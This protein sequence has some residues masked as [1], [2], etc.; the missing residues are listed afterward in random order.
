MFNSFS[1][2]IDDEKSEHSEH[3]TDDESGLDQDCNSQVSMESD[4]IIANKTRSRLRINETI[5]TLITQG[6][7]PDD[8]QDSS[9][10]G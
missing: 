3:V 7:F 4:K 8:E 9:F 10:L 1:S 6:P 5:E 2:K